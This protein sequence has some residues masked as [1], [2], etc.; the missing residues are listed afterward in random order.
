MLEEAQYMKHA[1]NFFAKGIE[2]RQS[3]KDDPEA[4]PQPAAEPEPESSPAPAS[5][6]APE[7]NV[8]EGEKEPAVPDHDSEPEPGTY[9]DLC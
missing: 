2:W 7:A 3:I 8:E 5:A 4:P 9:D 6:P 1:T